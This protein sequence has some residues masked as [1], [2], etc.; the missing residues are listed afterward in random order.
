MFG[1]PIEE[2]CVGPISHA[3]AQPVNC[4]DISDVGCYMD[5]KGQ[6]G[7]K[8]NLLANVSKVDCHHHLLSGCSFCCM[9]LRVACGRSLWGK[10]LWF[11]FQLGENAGN[12]KC[13]QC[14][15]G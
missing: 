15:L 2:T 13:R 1:I 11:L 4:L 14:A 7:K 3:E 5:G 10:G 9:D 6:R 8:G 12:D